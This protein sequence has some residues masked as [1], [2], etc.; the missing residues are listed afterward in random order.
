MH[1]VLMSAFATIDDLRRIQMTAIHFEAPRRRLGAV[2]HHRRRRAAGAVARQ[3]FTTLR[4]WR[5]RAHDRAELASLDDR[6]LRDIGLTRAD[7]EFLSNK[8]FW[9]E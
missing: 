7:A 5:R 6:M 3:F 8:P 9:R 2:Q 1:V 4:Q